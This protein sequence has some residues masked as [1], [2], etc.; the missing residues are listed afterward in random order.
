MVALAGAPASAPECRIF[1]IDDSLADAFIA[2]PATQVVAF[3]TLYFAVLYFATGGLTWW[4]T[5]HLLPRI[6]FGRVIDS[7]PLR[8]GQL[9]REIGESC[10]SIA[11]FGIGVLL[12]WWMLRNG[13]AKLAVDASALRIA[14][15]IAV[16]FVWNELHFYA[17]HRLLH[18]RVLRRFHVDHHRSLTPTPFSTY[19]FHPV[20]AVMLGSVPIIPMLLH[21][22]SFMALLSLPVF[23]I[24]LNN[25]GHA[26][27]EFSRRAPARGPLAA[28]RRHH[29]HHAQYHGN[30]GFLLDVFDRLAGSVIV[31]G[32]AERPR[33]RPPLAK[34]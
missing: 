4:L 23:S 29:L 9:R 27:Y 12:P 31:P 32:N 24:V 33:A 10:I 3:G 34:E 6:G 13:W 22:F 18:T 16:L 5:R 28:S 17:N 30:Y 2:L 14:T 20:E 7:R 1:A 26:N 8:P 21:D 25:L 19:A 15:E 11:I